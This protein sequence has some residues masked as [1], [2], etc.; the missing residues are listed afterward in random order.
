MA[1]LITLDNTVDRVVD[2]ILRL[3]QENDKLREEIK[4]LQE[5]QLSRD[6][7]LMEKLDNAVSSLRGSSNPVGR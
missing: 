3:Q 6:K 4:I 2:A 5:S 7:M 1:D